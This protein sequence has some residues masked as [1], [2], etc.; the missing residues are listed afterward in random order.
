MSHRDGRRSL[1]KA[2]NVLGC[3][4]L[5]FGLLGAQAAA[6]SKGVPGVVARTLPAVVSITT[7][8]IERDEFNQ[9]VATRGLGSGV[10]VDPR[11]YILTNS[12]VVDGAQEI[13]VTFVDG[14]TF[15]ASLVGTDRFTDL[16]VVKIDGKRFAVA[17]LGD[18]RKLSVGETV[19]A[20]GN[21]LW[22]E[23][24]P[25]VTVGIVSALGRTM[26]QPGL[27]ILHDLIQTDAAINPGN[28]GG[29]LVNLAG[30]V[31]GINTAV[32]SSAHGI[33]FAISANTARP[34]L[35]SLIAHGRIERPSLGLDAVSVTPQMAY[36]NDL[37]MERGV[38]VIRVEADG[39]AAV[40]GIQPGDVI[41]R[42]DGV[43]MKDLHQFHRALG[44]RLNQ[45]RVAVTVS[46]DGSELTLLPIVEIRQ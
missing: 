3:A 39:P 2:V 21:P 23:G 37:P 15:R 28:S 8:Q 36:A 46:R 32:I 22:I 38:L 18:S 20:I 29:P 31:V 41:T 27:P 24:G 17:R 9:A 12:H 7:R 13:K 33:S 14:H 11:G 35:A 26:E 45:E 25:S 19:V 6:S 30:Q 44:R 40:A 16:A 5:T 34:V 10:I 4:A 42:M 1:M 43:P